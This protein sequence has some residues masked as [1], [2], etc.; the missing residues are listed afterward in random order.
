MPGILQSGRKRPAQSISD[1]EDEQSDYTSSVSVGSKR[2]RHGRDASDS[3]AGTNDQQTQDGGNT[4][5]EDAFQPGSLVRVKLKNFVTYTDAEFHLG[6]SLNM[7]IGPNGTGKST[8]VC[9]ICLGL[10]WGSE[11]LGRAKDLGAFVKHG[12]T[13]AMIEI[14]LAAGPG[15]GQNQ[16]VQRI[17]RKEDNKSIFKLNGD[18]STQHKVT[19]MAKAYSIQID[20]LCQ[21][22]PQDRV[23]EFAKM[24]DVD[25][26]RETQRAAAP[27]Y[28]V[29]WHDQL[30]GLR[31]EERGLETKQTNEESHLKALVARQEATKG[32]VE[33]YHQREGL[34][35]KSKCL[36]KVRPIIEI[37]LRRHEI[38]QVKADLQTAKQELQQIT[39]DIEPVR[40]AQGELETYRNQI[41]QV[42]KLRRD[43]VNRII[44]QAES[45]AVKIEKE[46]VKISDSVGEIKAELNSKKIR[47]KDITRLAAEIASLEQQRQAQPV[48]YDAEVYKQGKVNLRSQMTTATISHKESK[49]KYDDLAKGVHIL[50]KRYEMLRGQRAQLDT[51]TGMQ[52][53]LLERASHDTA[54]AW[55]W[56]QANKDTL[57]LKGEVVGPPILEC[58]VPDSRYVNIVETL[59]RTGDLVAITCTNGDD[60]R[61]LSNRF[62]SKKENGGL[63]LHDIYL[64]TLPKSLSSYRPPVAPA[65]LPK[66]GFEGYI[67]DYIRGPDAVLAMLCDNVRLHQVAFATRPISEE[68]HAAVLDS[69]IRKWISG[70]DIFQ[71]AVRKEY[72]ASSTSV[73]QVRQAQWFIKQPVNTEE[74]R[75]LDDKM[76]EIQRERAEL[77]ENLALVKKDIKELEEQLKTFK[78]ELEDLQKE[79][80]TSKKAVAVWAAL[81]GKVALKQTERDTHVQQNAET[82]NTIRAIKAVSRDASLNVASLTLDHAKI[83]TQMRTLHESLVEAEIR[84]IEAKSEF[85][86]LKAE[87]ADID[88]KLKVKQD[89][90]EGLAKRY[91]TLCVDFR[92]MQETTQQDI[93]L[94]SEEEKK[95]VIEYRDLPSLDALEQEVQ[96]VGARLEMMADGNPGAIRAYEKREEEIG[97]TREKLERHTA[98][99]HDAKKKIA[100]IRERWEPELDALIRK[101]SDAFAH[102]FEQIGC[103]G[104]V[105]VY[106]DEE[107]FDNWSIQISVRFREGEPLSV[108]NSHRQSGG[109]RAVSTIFYLMALQDLAQ[110]PF[111]VVDEINQGM[112][113]RNERM[114]HERMVDIACQERTSQYFLV[115]PKL[116]TGL[117]FHPKMKV[118]VINSGEHIPDSKDVQGGWDLKAMAKVALRVRK[119]VV[120]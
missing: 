89:E 21:F 18:R 43:R 111:R 102:N 49:N 103:A 75:E 77:A 39:A 66:Y 30:K 27:A 119:G 88:R 97:K 52:L 31:S 37:R 50:S 100:E 115:T 17:I 13:E 95:I 62:L 110:S 38:Q 108:L 6:P 12:S 7:V 26:L 120:V 2:A 23:V 29:E 67:L 81:P 91:K 96:A 64:R 112:D 33:H 41:E 74:K 84:W 70:T 68:Q 83:V 58:T 105:E 69:A 11:H 15:K 118:H 71:I 90:Q 25:R 54:T 57:P 63:G 101:I 114:V 78:K 19:T 36:K 51:Q 35:Q 53:S 47:E 5:V 22:L 59:L 116:L 20:N 82:N 113:P 45:F 79:E 16:I 34:L 106:K 60:Q 72:N 65:E 9:A 3:P 44:A 55:R 10:G 28:M 98:S 73:N 85:N 61:L 94:L 80:D 92:R 42:V 48:A 4:Y 40:Q 99:L 86:A 87:N 109:E 56:F 14:E 107:D 1:D 117:K 46:K 93:N 32:D 24:T 8:L 76:Q 104:E